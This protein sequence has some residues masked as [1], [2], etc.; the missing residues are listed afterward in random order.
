[1][2]KWIPDYSNKHSGE[3]K[4]TLLKK[5]MEKVINKTGLYPLD[6]YRD[7]FGT[8]AILFRDFILVAK[9]ES[10][11]WVVSCHKAILEECLKKN[12]PLCMYVEKQDAFY[13]FDPREA[14]KGKINLREGIEFVNFPY[15]EGNRTYWS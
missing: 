9:K 12:K 7:E 13:L 15:A 4:R 10:Y 11:G 1:M 14:I 3:V 8:Y 5:A 2:T 6:K